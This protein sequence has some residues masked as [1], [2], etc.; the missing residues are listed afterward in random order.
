VLPSQVY[1]SN[2]SSNPRALFSLVRLY[3]FVRWGLASEAAF[4][5]PRYVDRTRPTYLPARNAEMR[6]ENQICSEAVSI[7]PP[8][9]VRGSAIEELI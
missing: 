9:S 2:L 1:F 7:T 5:G 3:L 8:R 6:L 4:A